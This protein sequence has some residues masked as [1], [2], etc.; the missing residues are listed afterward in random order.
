MERANQPMRPRIRKGANEGQ[1]QAANDGGRAWARSPTRKPA[2]DPRP[3]GPA[4]LLHSRRPPP[5]TPGVRIQIMEHKSMTSW[6]IA[7]PKK[8]PTRP[9]NRKIV[10]PRMG[11]VGG[12]KKISKQQAENRGKGLDRQRNE[13]EE[14]IAQPGKLQRAMA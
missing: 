3:H 12:K 4:R 7:T 10:P 8:V 13:Q 14:E 6:M 9:A 11:G 1:H 5:A 2:P